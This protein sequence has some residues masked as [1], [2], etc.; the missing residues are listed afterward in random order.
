MRRAFSLLRRLPSAATHGAKAPAAFVVPPAVARRV[1]NLHHLRARG[2]AA[3][4]R[5]LA[6]LER[7]PRIV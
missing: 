4:S 5:P 3:P 1:A 6:G 2:T 7:A